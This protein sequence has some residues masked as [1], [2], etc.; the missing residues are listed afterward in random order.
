MSE[1]G[2]ENSISLIVPWFMVISPHPEATKSSL[3]RKD[4]PIL[5]G[6]RS[7]VPVTK[8]KRQAYIY[9]TQLQHMR[10]IASPVPQPTFP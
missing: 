9:H 8:D 5:K 10:T 6:F 7:C 1:S 2:P 4:A 3:I